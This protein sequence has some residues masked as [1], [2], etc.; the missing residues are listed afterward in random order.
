MGSDNDVNRKASNKFSPLSLFIIAGLVFCNF[1]PRPNAVSESSHDDPTFNYESQFLRTSQQQ[2]DEKRVHSAAL[3]PSAEVKDESTSASAKSAH[4]SCAGEMS[5]F[6]KPTKKYVTTDSRRK[7]FNR[8]RKVAHNMGKAYLEELRSNDKGLVGMKS[9]ALADIPSDPKSVVEY[10][11]RVGWGNSEVPLT[12]D[13]SYPGQCAFY[14][15]NCN[16]HGENLLGRCF[17]MPGW[18]GEHCE[19]EGTKVPCTH[20]DDKCFYSPEAG[21]FAISYARWEMSQ[22]A[23]KRTWIRMS[24]GNPLFDRVDEH[25]TDFD[26]YRP[27]GEDGANLGKFLE[28]GAGPWTQSKW[29]MK[30]RG[31]KVDRYVLL[32]PGVITYVGNVESTV[33]KRG[34]MEGFEGKTVVIQ[35]GGEHLDIFHESFDTVMM[36]NV[37][38]HVVNAIMLLRNV[39]NSLK[40]G[41]LLIFSDCWMTEEQEKEGPEYPFWLDVSYLFCFQP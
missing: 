10:V 4:I 13:Q 9:G 24:R 41:G 1:I 16:L 21:I 5:Q 2:K 31:F 6:Y 37:L 36:V 14:Q 7:R 20:K 3:Q 39:Y 17:C 34:E 30:Q 23:E 40:P 32:D 38:Q 33:F 28:V 25:L 11:Q 19:N 18:T 27:V 15:G 26:E 12:V 35:G 29:M 8:V 22:E